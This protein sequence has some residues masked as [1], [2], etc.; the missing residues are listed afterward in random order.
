[1]SIQRIGA[2]GDTKYQNL[3]RF[4]EKRWNYQKQKAFVKPDIK[5]FPELKG[6]LAKLFSKRL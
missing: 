2:H 6:Y 1:M 5:V 4:S 3:S